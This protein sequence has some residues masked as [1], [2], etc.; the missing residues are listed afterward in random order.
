MSDNAFTNYNNIITRIQHTA[1]TCLE[2][3][4]PCTQ[5][6]INGEIRRLSVRTA[7]L[8]RM[9]ILKGADPALMQEIADSLGL[10]LYD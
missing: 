1:R 2:T 5:V 3:I 8:L 9:A 6:A 7:H 10:E 4:E